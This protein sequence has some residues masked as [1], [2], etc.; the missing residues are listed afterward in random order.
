MGIKLF[1]I[2]FIVLFLLGCGK[3]FKIVERSNA[4]VVKSI[5][6]T[7]CTLLARAKTTVVTNINTYLV[8]GKF[9]V[10]NGTQLEIVK[11]DDGSVY[12]S[13]GDKF[14]EIVS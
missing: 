1:V 14:H 4:G 5:S 2:S 12:L 10:K 13:C 7:N 6:Y 3:N 9:I 11:F 8:D